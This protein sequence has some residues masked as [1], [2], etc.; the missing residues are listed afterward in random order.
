MNDSYNI[1]RKNMR[2]YRKKLHYTQ[3][4]VADG[5]RYSLDYYQEVESIKRQKRFSITFAD[6]VAD[7]YGIKTRDLLEDDN[8]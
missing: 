8:E 3:Q 6:L 4:Q 7:F 1:M 5:I 2:K